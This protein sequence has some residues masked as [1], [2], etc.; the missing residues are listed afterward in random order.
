DLG[1][2]R[3][4]A[5]SSDSLLQL[6][7]CLADELLE[8]ERDRALLRLAACARVAALQAGERRPLERRSGEEVAVLFAAGAEA[9]VADVCVQRLRRPRHQG[10]FRSL[11]VW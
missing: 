8:L 6:G 10:L 7:L 1:R 11:W 2:G 3:V 5:A 4:G 9:A